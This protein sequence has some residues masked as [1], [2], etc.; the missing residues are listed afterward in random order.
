MN[1]GSENR[2][3]KISKLCD[4]GTKNAA[5]LSSESLAERI[6]YS[7]RAAVRRSLTDASVSDRRV[8]E[9]HAH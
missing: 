5:R 8:E 1:I 2:H 4:G 7:G 9:S 3:P 6:V